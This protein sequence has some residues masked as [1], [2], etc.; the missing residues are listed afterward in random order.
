MGRQP[1]ASTNDRKGRDVSAAPALRSMGRPVLFGLFCVLA[2][3]GGFGAW[4]YVIPLD[5]AIIAKGTVMPGERRTTVKHPQGGVI[6]QIAVTEGDTVSEGD[7]LLV[8]DQVGARSRFQADR[9]KLRTLAAREAR[10]IAERDRE[11]AIRYDHPSLKDI[12]DPNVS[13]IIEAQNTLFERR[14]EDLR[15]RQDIL[16]QRSSQAQARRDGLRAQI[17]ALGEQRA[18]IGDELD[19]VQT[20]FDKGLAPK[21]RLLELKRAALQLEARQ[22]ELE[23]ELAPVSEEKSELTLQIAGQRIRFADGVAAELAQVQTERAVLEEQINTSAQELGRTEIRAPTDGAVIDIR[24]A[25]T[26]GVI[27]PGGAILDIVPIRRDLMVETRIAPTD[28]D[29][30]TL[31]ME[32][33]VAFPAISARMLDKLTG[34][35]VQLSADTLE[36]ERTGERFYKA[37][38]RIDQAEMQAKLGDVEL[39]PGMPVEVFLVTSKRS[40]FE[41][42]A[43]PVNQLL[44]RSMRES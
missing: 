25:S 40:L 18:L 44:Q 3:F 29:E 22:G 42:L 33:R 20:L 34:Q 32:T 36:D 14:R 23:A 30:L 5:G 31:D 16:S 28:I 39:L 12:S 27:A 8:L 37:Q 26:G 43:D 21:T 35:L 7:L 4:A 19:G 41:Y 11:R 38:I 1:I 17:T 13:R 2:F 15:T 24:V 6:A 9:E 10:L